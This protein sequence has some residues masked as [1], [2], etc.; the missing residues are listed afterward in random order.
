MSQAAAG[1]ATFL[2]RSRA[3]ARGPAII[4]LVIALL[5]ISLPF[6]LLTSQFAV[7]VAIRV[8]VFACLSLGWNLI[9]GFG[10]Q[11]SFGNVMFFG[12]GAYTS[13]LLLINFNLS[14]WIGMLAGVALSCAAA[15]I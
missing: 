9:G 8:L 13:T 6:W 11:V 12:L 10:G 5:A 15:L 2:P 3:M 1:H 7:G 4:W 14:P